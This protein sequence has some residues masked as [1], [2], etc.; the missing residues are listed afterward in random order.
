M[1]LVVFGGRDFWNRKLLFATLDDVHKAR[2]ITCLIEGGASGTDRLARDWAT[3]RGVPFKTV[4]ADWN[5][6]DVKPCVPRKR[7]DGSLYNA[8]AGGIRNQLMIDQERPDAGLA[9]PGGS[10]TADM[11]RRMRAAGIEPQVIT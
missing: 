11:M 5:N 1:R 3:A 4:E 10:G 6:M 7:R 2:P 8:A 9:F